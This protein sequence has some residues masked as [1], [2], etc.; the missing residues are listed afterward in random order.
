MGCMHLRGTQA[1]RT[2]D[3]S[4]YFSKISSGI[5]LYGRIPFSLLFG[6]KKKKVSAFK[7]GLENHFSGMICY[8]DK[9]FADKI[10]SIHLIR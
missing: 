7:K 9:I 1:G 2:R 4:F 3:F 6:K 5:L 10:A 8:C